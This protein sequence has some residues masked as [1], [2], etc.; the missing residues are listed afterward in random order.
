MFSGSV[1]MR[2]NVQLVAC[3]VCWAVFAVSAAPQSET[4]PPAQVE[5]PER[6]ARQRPGEYPAYLFSE[7]FPAPLT[8]T[9][10]DFQQKYLFGDWMGVPRLYREWVTLRRRPL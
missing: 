7:H 9:S 6:S 2:P 10:E 3:A 1:L 5:L 8:E 4:I